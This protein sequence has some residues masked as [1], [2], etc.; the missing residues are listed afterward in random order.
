MSFYFAS[1]NR[2]KR[3]ITID[4]KQDKGRQIIL[5]LAKQSDIMYVWHTMDSLQI[6]IPLAKKR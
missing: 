4:L 3:S 6:M 1:T 2:N 5:E